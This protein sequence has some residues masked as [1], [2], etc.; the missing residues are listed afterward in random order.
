MVSADVQPKAQQ[1]AVG[2]GAIAFIHKPVA[3]EKLLP[4]LRQ[5][6]RYD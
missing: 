4:I 6:G 3:P 5:Y 1:R 2:L